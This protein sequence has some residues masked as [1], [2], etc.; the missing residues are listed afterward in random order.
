[1]LSGHE[2]MKAVRR[3]FSAEAAR[4]SPWMSHKGATNSSG[5][6]ETS[7]SHKKELYL[8]FMDEET[9]VVKTKS[10]CFPKLC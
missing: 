7:L 4:G 9:E 2:D 10:Q 1:M 3:L 6:L 5:T 8:Y